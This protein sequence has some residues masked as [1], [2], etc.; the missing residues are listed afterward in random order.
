MTET[1]TSPTSGPSFSTENDQVDGYRKLSRLA[2]WSIPLG[3]LSALSLISPLLWFI[4]LVAIAFALGGLWNISHST[5]TTGRRLALIGLVIALLFGTW[6]V[7]WTLSRQFIIKQQATKHAAEW[8]ELMQNQE[9]MQG[10]QLCLDYY[11]RR[12]PG[13]SLEKHYAINES[14]KELTEVKPGVGLPPHAE[15]KGFMEYG[16]PKHLVDV[17]GDFEFQL[18]KNLLILREGPFVT[19]VDQ[20]YRITFPDGHQPPEMTLKIGMK[21]TVDAG[22]AYWQISPAT[23]PKTDGAPPPP[24]SV[25]HK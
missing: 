7:S 20:L 18:V 13:S 12:P 22:K 19:R 8:F 15:L 4:P 9:Y 5:D 11:D 2:V 16:I 25:K 17:D 1:Q 14:D 6:G 3:L 21:R 24:I 10:H 23:D